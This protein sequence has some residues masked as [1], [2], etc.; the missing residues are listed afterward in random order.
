[1]EANKLV[2]VCICIYNGEKYILETLESI[3]AQTSTDFQL[4]MV[5]DASTDNGVIIAE[6]Y[7]EKNA[8]FPW[9][10]YNLPRNGG[11]ARARNFAERY[12]QTKYMIFFDADDLMKPNMVEVLLNKISSD[13]DLMAVGYYLDYID[14]NSKKMKGGLHIGAKTK[15]EFYQKASAGKLIFMHS[16]AIFNR[17][18]A[19]S[20]GGRNIDGFPEGKPYYQDMCEDCDLWTRM[21]DLY[22]DNKAIVAIPEVLGYYRKMDNTM[23][24]NTMAMKLRM[25][26]I[27]KNLRLRRSGMKEMD[28]DE[29][30][31]SLSEDEK[32]KLERECNA[33]DAFRKFGFAMVNKKILN[34]V[35]WFAVAFCASPKYVIDKLKPFFMK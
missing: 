25:M 26:Q 20:V 9:E 29:F 16:G 24:T 15:D 10:I 18:L 34:G 8:E 28:F 35:Y 22:V 19:L 17:E 23:S 32:K 5:N 30:R 1:M 27:K 21:S 14:A 6:E 2:T 4:L 13:T 7:L 11:L 12:V 33:T 31:N 3:V